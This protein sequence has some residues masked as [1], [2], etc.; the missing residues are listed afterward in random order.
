[1]GNALGHG[2][3]QKC[4]QFQKHSGGSKYV[5]WDCIKIKTL[6]YCN[7]EDQGHEEPTCRVGHDTCKSSFWLGASTQNL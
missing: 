1:M 5:K 7:E 3:K 4:I 2:M 6:L